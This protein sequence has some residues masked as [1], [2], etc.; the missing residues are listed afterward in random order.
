MGKCELISFML[1]YIYFYGI[2]LV[3]ACMVTDTI[4]IAT[5]YVMLKWSNGSKEQSGLIDK[6]ETKSVDN[7]VKMVS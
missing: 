1:A 7:Q 4:N 5:T 2:R 3:Y 6:S